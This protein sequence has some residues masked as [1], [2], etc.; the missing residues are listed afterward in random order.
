MYEADMSLQELQKVFQEAIAQERYEEARHA[1]EALWKAAPGP[2]SANV[3]VQGFAKGTLPAQWP[4][5][6]VAFARSWTVEAAVGLF[7]AQTLMAGL[8]VE[9]YVGGFDGYAQELME[10]HSALYAFKP[11]VIFLSLYAPTVIPELWENFSALD[12]EGVRGRVD[13]ALWLF[14]MLAGAVRQNSEAALFIETLQMPAEAVWNFADAQSSEMNRAEAVASINAAL[15]A[16]PERYPGLHVMD[17]NAARLRMGDGQWVDPVRWLTMRLPLSALALQEMARLWAGVLVAFAGRGAKVIVCDLDNTLWGGVLG[18]DGAEGIVLGREYPGAAYRTLQGVL[19]DHY[20]AGVLLAVCSKNN[21]EEAMQVLAEHSQMRLRPEHFSAF[22]INWND[23]ASGLE[24]IARRLNV[25]LDALLFIDDNPAECAWVR[26]RLPEVRVLELP[27]ENP[28]AYAG[29]L[30]NH[31]ALSRLKITGEDRARAGR[32]REQVQREALKEA[33]ATLEDYYCSL[34]MQ[35]RVRVNAEGDV[36]RVAQLTQRTNQFNLTTR[37]YQERDV[38]ERLEAVDWDVMAFELEDR[39][40]VQGV[41]GVIMGRNEGEVYW[42]D[43][44]LM[45]CRVI[46]RTVEDAMLACAASE[47]LRRGAKHLIGEFAETPKNVPCR[48]FYAK[49]GFDAQACDEVF[50]QWAVQLKSDAFAIPAWIQIKD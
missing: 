47:A 46:G 34:Q 38:W 44:F 1:A 42:L 27:V 40:G 32:Y 39:F 25:G 24:A 37:R 12:A 4:R 45:S 41:I 16:L 26:A 15:R 3:I 8:V 6:R 35:L 28:M 14:E 17:A 2:A 36:E 9:C 43:T 5:L 29:L 50:Q 13:E 10:A 23:K 30:L 33:S 20:R 7:Q 19:L 22:E 21:E 48:D 31:P 18:E 49:R 11:D